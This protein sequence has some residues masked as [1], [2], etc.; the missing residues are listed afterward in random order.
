MRWKTRVEEPKTYLFSTT[1]LGML[2]KIMCKPG[3]GWGWGPRSTRVARGTGQER[4]T[5]FFGAYCIKG[6]LEKSIFATTPPWPA[7]SGAAELIDR[8]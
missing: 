4:A 7:G 1:P 5:Q 6:D 2:Q 8:A 3:R